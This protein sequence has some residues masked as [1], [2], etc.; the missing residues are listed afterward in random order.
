MNGPYRI[1]DDTFDT[2]PY[3]DTPPYLCT[4]P[5]TKK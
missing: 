5:E 4:N 2:D 3:N 1:K